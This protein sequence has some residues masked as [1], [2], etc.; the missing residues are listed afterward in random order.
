ML[1]K[2]AKH[3]IAS[4]EQ[5]LAARTALLAKEK[6][7]TRLRDKLAAERR[8]LPWVKVEKDYVFDAPEGRKTL[9]DL[10]DGRSQLVVKHFMLGPGWKDGCIGC[11]FGADHID[12]GLMHLE[13]HDVSVVAVS[14]APLAE[15]EAYKKRM[16]WR[17]KW[18]SSHGND[19]N[20]D[21]HVSFTPEDLAKGKVYYNYAMIDAGIDELPGVS[22]FVRDAAGAIFHTYSSYGRGGEELITT[23]MV[24]DLTAKGRN[25]TGPHHNLMDWVRRHD[26]YE[27]TKGAASC[28]GS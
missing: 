8:A 22:V 26:E 15:I 3:P 14:R 12:G 6:E 18:A 7:F 9:G 27:D 24:L 5:W 28:C 13:H 20:Y 16:G 19:F 4:R 1:D 10:F 25:E 17:F 2:A 11:S 23:Y 21:Y